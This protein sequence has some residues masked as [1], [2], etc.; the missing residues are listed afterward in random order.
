ML[1]RLLATACLCLAFPAL[2]QDFHAGNIAISHPWSRSTAPTVNVGGAYLAISNHGKQ[3]DT[4]LSASSPR[5]GMVELHQN[6]NQ[7][8][9]LKMRELKDGLVIAPG[10]T[11]ALQP[12]GAHLMLMELAKP[13]KSG[14]HFPLTLTFKRAGKVTVEVSVDDGAA[15]GDAHQH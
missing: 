7:N 4:L 2:A 14:E 15:A 3:P 13:L 11:V 9:V 1:N 12:G 5:A 8:G 10:Q 6:L